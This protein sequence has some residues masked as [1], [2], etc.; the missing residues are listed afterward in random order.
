MVGREHSRVKRVRDFVNNN[1]P[2]S[3]LGKI[4]LDFAFATLA[5]SICR[6]ANRRHYPNVNSQTRSRT[7]PPKTSL[8]WISSGFEVCAPVGRLTGISRI[9]AREEVFIGCICTNWVPNNCDTVLDPFWLLLDQH[10]IDLMVQ[11]ANKTI[12]LNVVYIAWVVT[13][14][15]CW[16]F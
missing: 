7:Y 4:S 3:L 6:T 1:T 8:L 12:I 11:L 14:N 16:R 10:I 13:N 2:H 5:N 15:K 9:I